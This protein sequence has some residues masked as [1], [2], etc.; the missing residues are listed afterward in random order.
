MN[1]IPVSKLSTLVRGR[2]LVGL[3]ILC[4]GAR[5][6]WASGEWFGSRTINGQS[7]PLAVLR[8]AQQRGEQRRAASVIPSRDVFSASGLPLNIPDNDP[9]GVTA[10]LPVNHAG[11]ATG[12]TV[13]FHITHTFIGDLKVT[14]IA[15]SGATYVL[16]DRSGGS[17]ANLSVVDQPVAAA[18]GE[19][20]SGT[21]QLFVQDLASG[22]TGTLDSF[23]LSITN[24][25]NADIDLVMSLSANPQGDDNGNSQGDPNSAAQ[26]KWERIVQHF[27]DGV[28]ESTNAAHKIRNVRIF[29]NGRAAAIADV[30]W[31]AAGHPHVPAK[32]GVGEAGGHIN[33][34]ETFTAG[35]AGG[36][37]YD[38]LADEIGSGYTQAHE[39]GH[40]FYGVYDEYKINATDVPVVPS[41]MD[42]QWMATGGDNQWLNFSIKNTG[43]GSFQDTLHTIQHDQHGAS[44]WETLARPTSQ[45]IKTAAQLILGK[46]IFYPEVAAAAP[47]PGGTPRIDLPGTAR[48]DLNIIWMNDE[49]VYEV[50]IDHSGSMGDENKMEQAKAAAQLLINLLPLGKARVGVIEFDDTVSE[51]QPIILLTSQAD[52][53]S[54]KA[55]IAAIGPAGST[56]IGDAAQQALTTILDP[57]LTKSNR[58]VFLLTDGLSNTGIDPL[59]VIPS[60][61]NAQIPLFT[62][63]FGS[64]ADTVTLFRLATDTGGKFYSSPASLAAITNAFHD[65]QTVA[66]SI[67]ALGANTLALGSGSGAGTFTVDSTIGQ[68]NLSLVKPSDPSIQVQVTDPGGNPVTPDDTF[69]VGNEVLLSH[70]ITNPAAGVWTVSSQGAVAGTIDY[71]ASGIPDELTYTIQVAS[72]GGS[73]VNLPTPVTLRARLFK[74][75]PIN[76]AVATAQ[77]LAPSGAID[78]LQFYDDGTHGDEVANDGNYTANY[79]YTETGIYTFK[80]NAAAT[81]GQSS[82]TYTGATDTATVEGLPPTPIPDRPINEAFT[83]ASQLQITIGGRL[84]DNISTR[85]FVQTGDHVM[86]G[87][88]IISGTGAKTVLFRALG[89]TLA[90]SPFFLPQSLGDPVLELHDGSGAVIA[91]N[92]NWEQAPNAVSIPAGLRPPNSSEAAILI[93]LNPGSYTAIVRGANH[94]TGNALVEAYDLDVASGSTLGNISTRGE[95]QTGDG[96]MIAGVIVTGTELQQVLVR[97]LGPTLAQPPF[98]VPGVLSDPTLEL[99]DANGSVISTNDNWQD[100]QGP[101]IQATGLAPP[102][103]AESAI[104]A[105]L[106]PGQYTAIVRG[107]N[108]TTGVA[109]VEVY[110]LE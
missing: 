32:G 106:N 20:A 85:A 23:S 11:L 3:T 2:A 73:T 7:E 109:L 63:A 9:A 95:V 65:A 44:A 13:S 29:R 60:Y 31:T 35:G 48:S 97:A 98:N 87:G 47:A 54:V 17:T 18:T 46:R 101:Q 70:T 52:K 59:S 22:D 108:H 55:E 56:A 21:W 43:G 36:A 86:I 39:W 81:A 90:Q 82:A 8:G 1:N 66:S 74:E 75:L 14:L 71:T 96:V 37:D 77:I 25:G 4:C 19:T 26:D 67:P 57:A 33:M 58:V 80:V 72:T 40:F 61:Q 91:T 105:P 78:T 10:N 68:L 88:V 93:T 6:V 15:P 51:I 99:H 103:P 64:D 42:S 12:L 94:T 83:R 69:T 5:L 102:N 76:L 38:M 110:A 45:D 50:V 16:S 92:D 107:L 104:L 24:A 62:F 79:H 41:I 49:D 34:Y 53:D 89:P 100:T 84:L 27:A 30:L 28:Y